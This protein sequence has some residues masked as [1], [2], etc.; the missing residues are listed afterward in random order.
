MALAANAVGL[1]NFLRFAGK[2][3][4]YGGAFMVPYLLAL[5]L[6]GVPLMWMELT[7]GRHGGGFGHGSTPG[8]FHRLWR[9]PL[10]KY[11]GIL[12][13]LLPAVVAL[14]Y[15]Y[16]ES[17]CLGYAWQTLS[18]SYWGRASRAEMGEVFGDY[19]G[20]GDKLVSL[21]P[22]SHG[23]T[24]S[25]GR[26]AYLFFIIA[27][28]VNMLFFARGI[29]KGIELL[30]KY[31]MPLLVVMGIIVA[32]RV[33]TLSPVEG[34]TV[35]DGLARIWVIDWSALKNPKMW[36][37]A[38]GQIFF[39]LSVGLGM[40]HAYASVLRK[41]E[42]V[43]LNGLATTATNEF[44]EVILGGSIVIPAAAVFFGMSEFQQIVQRG[45]FADL[46][47]QTLPVIFQ[48]M[49][50]G[51]F[52]GAIWF[53]LLFLAALT[54]SVAMFTPLLMFLQD[55]LN[56]DRK[57]ALWTIGICGFV[58]AQPA[59]L[60][61]H[62]G[63]MDELDDWAGTLLLVLFVAIETVIFSWVYGIDKGWR[64][65]HLGA[66]IRVPR[67]FYY[68]MKYVTPLF[69]IGMLAWFAVLEPIR[70]WGDPAAMANTFWGKLTMMA[71][72]DP[73]L[74][75]YAPENVP[76]LWLARA[77]PVGGFILLALGVRYAWRTHP[78]FFEEEEAS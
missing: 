32:V 39:T 24:L 11:L 50:G 62:R 77:I 33:L 14:Y 60:F 1:G 63:V 13:V 6:L 61:F 31:A 73:R 38:T 3:A 71:V 18:G 15:M 44:V 70:A 25:L 67:I 41:D 48:K 68:V 5:V 55:E 43:T 46:G 74:P 37:D 8:M 20:L 69:A 30:C 16:I 52:F 7:I 56:L 45:S 49:A 19:L 42:D 64:E 10:S 2:A 34:R 36:V 12:G 40:T 59:I 21:G 76:Y 72:R 26:Q 58:L 75:T 9:H 47:F 23:I 53:I 57:K 65:M 17:W 66:D 22:G 35:S 51:P 78:K 27:F 29:E 28:V 54:S 4:P